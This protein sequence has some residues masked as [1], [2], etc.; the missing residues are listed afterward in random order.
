MAKRITTQ[1]GIGDV[2]PEATLHIR[3]INLDEVGVIVQGTAKGTQTADLEQWK[4]SAG[5]QVGEMSIAGYF[6]SVR[7]S[8]STI[9][10]PI[11]IATTVKST[12]CTATT[13][14]GATLGAGTVYVA[15]V[16]STTCTATTV[17]STT[18][19]ATGFTA[20]ASGSV[21][22]PTAMTPATSSAAGTVGMIAWDTA[23]K[24]GTLYVCTATDTWQKIAV[25]GW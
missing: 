17:K 14:Q 10:T 11:T 13:F 25:A 7:L 8:G 6:E 5:T 1:T 9:E 22:Y 12:T 16:N 19:T 21:L 24:T 2:N 18:C 15:N 3:P 23:G 4:N 20:G